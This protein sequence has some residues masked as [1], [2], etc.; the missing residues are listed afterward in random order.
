MVIPMTLFWERKLDKY[1]HLWNFPAVTL[2]THCLYVCKSV[3]LHVVCLSIYV[4]I[5][6]YMCVCVCV[7]V[8]VYMRTKEIVKRFISFEM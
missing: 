8:Y 5:H 7:C 2:E 4:C 3:C 6:I 1:K